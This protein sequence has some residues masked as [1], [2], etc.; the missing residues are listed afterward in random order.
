M[1]WHP[2]LLP[3]RIAFWDLDRRDLMT[4]SGGLVSNVAN[5]W[6]PGVFD[7]G[8][9]TS[10]QRPNS[11]NYFNGKHYLNYSGQRGD[12]L[13]STGG[14]VFYPPWS[15]AIF[16]RPQDPDIVGLYYAAADPMGRRVG[17]E[18]SPASW[19]IYNSNYGMIRRVGSV[20]DRRWHLLVLTESNAGY[21]GSRMYL[22]GE[23][24]AICGGGTGA[25]E[26]KATQFLTGHGDI[27][28]SLTINE[29]MTPAQVSLLWEWTKREYSLASYEALGWNASAQPGIMENIVGTPPVLLEGKMS[30]SDRFGLRKVPKA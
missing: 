5:V 30:A 27:G 28:Y 25:A 10:G 14:S 9:P 17:A 4:E 16:L 29:V 23:F 21:Y 13:I 8:Q 6:N 7:M 1:S 22:D 19:Y 12:N 18:T 15:A 24:A 26:V 2:D 11:G 20:K 3:K